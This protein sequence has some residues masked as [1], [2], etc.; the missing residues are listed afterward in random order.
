MSAVVDWKRVESEARVPPTL[1]D[2]VAAVGSLAASEQETVQIV[3]GLLRSGRVRAAGG[4]DESQRAR[5]LSRSPLS[6]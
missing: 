2:L 3:A 6:R 1:L 5:A 4:F